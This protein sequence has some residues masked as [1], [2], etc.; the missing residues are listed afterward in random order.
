MGDCVEKGS[1]WLGAE[2]KACFG[3]EVCN[4]LA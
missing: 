1:V 2:K 4:V 3:L